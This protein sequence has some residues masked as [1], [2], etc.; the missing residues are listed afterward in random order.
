MRYAD[1]CNVSGRSKR[2][3]ERVMEGLVGLSAELALPINPAK[4]AVAP[5]RERSFLG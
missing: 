5:A 2:A 1:A 4:S 3:G